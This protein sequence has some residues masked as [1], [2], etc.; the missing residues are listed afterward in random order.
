MS[1]QRG[2]RRSV[3]N[4]PREEIPVYTPND[5]PA[6]S[7]SRPPFPR[8]ASQ[9]TSQSRSEAQSAAA[10]RSHS[11]TAFSQRSLSV[12]PDFSTAPL[13]IESLAGISMNPD[14]YN[15][16]G[17]DMLLDSTFG[18][19]NFMG[20]NNSASTS[21][22]YQDFSSPLA[23]TTR[24]RK[25][26]LFVDPMPSQGPTFAQSSSQVNGLRLG[27]DQLPLLDSGLVA[28]GSRTATKRKRSRSPSIEFSSIAKM[29]P[30]HLSTEMADVQFKQENDSETPS[31]TLKYSQL[32]SIV[33]N[34]FVQLLLKTGKAK[35]KPQIVKEKENNEKSFRKIPQS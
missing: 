30:L 10:S 25:K 20:N 8:S 9:A 4:R 27:S 1:S 28:E 29:E 14:P 31:S 2:R 34:N 18:D 35:E 24:M 21:I 3:A 19:N 15:T 5:L 23:P 26:E 7:T 32:P 11:P 16:F 13:E 12:H 17:S 33:S 22:G 6:P